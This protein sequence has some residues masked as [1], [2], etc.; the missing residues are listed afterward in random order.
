MGVEVKPAVFRTVADGT[1]PIARCEVAVIG[2]GPYGLA[3]AAH[4]RAANVTTQ[5][6]GEPMG[7]WRQN[8]PKGM[9]LRSPWRASHIA[10]PAKK[11]SL[12]AYTSEKGLRQTE[13]FPLDEFVRY[14][15]WFQSK[16]VP[17]LDQR[18]VMRVDTTANGFRLRLADGDMVQ[19]KRVVIAMGLRN[20]EFRPA[21][22]EGLP[23]ALVSHSAEHADLALFR[24]KLVAVVGRGQSALECAVLLS[25][26]GADVELV[27]RGPVRWLGS[28]RCGVTPNTNFTWSLESIKSAPS[29]VGPFPLNWIIE[30]PD[31]MRYLPADLRSWISTR[32]LRP[33]ASAWL[34][35]RADRVH[36]NAGGTVVAARPQGDQ[37]ALQFDDGSKS[38]VDH[39]LLATGYRMNISKFGVLAPDLISKVDCI[40]GYPQLSSGFQS[41][42]TGLHFIGSSAVKSFG[43]L[44]RF[45]AGA[46]YAARSLTRV[47]RGPGR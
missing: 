32:S 24:G 14:G 41:S 6:F 8:M 4:L 13:N 43:G 1:K 9:K 2:A 23:A 18:K 31:V 17:D 30:A 11:Y 21:E 12:E 35:P 19:A 36:F 29:A 39:V 33:A 10:D 25:E 28:E 40:D 46:G 16:V 34:R 38:V 37:L 20:Q 44:M 7:F 3:A 22:F 42:V 27:S 26:G 15:E 45:V 5:V 47:A